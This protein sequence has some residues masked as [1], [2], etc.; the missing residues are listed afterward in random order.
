M[1]SLQK[2][3]G[4][5]V[6]LI[7]AIARKSLNCCTNFLQLPKHHLQQLLRWLQQKFTATGLS[8]IS[9][10]LTALLRDRRHRRRVL[11]F[12]QLLL[13]HRRLLRYL[14]QQLFETTPFPSLSSPSSSLL[15]SPKK[16]ATMTKEMAS[17]MGVRNLIAMRN[18]TKQ[19]NIII[20]A[21]RSKPGYVFSRQKH[22]ACCL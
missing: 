5:C 17:S 20:D 2:Q 9:R 6:I 15:P 8:S 21:R 7:D 4:F 14:M 11:G 10:G 18:R 3:V 19:D 16:M 1:K 22:T 12:L 13:R